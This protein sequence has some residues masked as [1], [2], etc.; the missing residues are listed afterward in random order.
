MD[1]DYDIFEIVKVDSDFWLFDAESY[2]RS[3]KTRHGQP[4]E[5]GY[6]V[7]NWPEQIQVRRFDE[8]A[9]YYGPFESRAEAK[10]ALVGMYQ[11]RERIL[12]M[13]SEKTSGCFDNTAHLFEKK[14]A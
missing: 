7:V 2:Q 4:L 14:V 6:F 5:Q 12:L 10:S 3:Y 1:A 9:S 11:Q 13:A 8:Y